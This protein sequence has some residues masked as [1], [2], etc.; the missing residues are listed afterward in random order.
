MP[1]Q[2]SQ[3]CRDLA[4]RE[5]VFARLTA[6][7]GCPDPFEW[8]DGGRTG[9]S[10][11][12]AMLLHITGQ[13]ISAA[14]AF[15]VYDRIS[16]A[17]GGVPEPARILGL[18]PGRLRACGLS[19]AKAGYAVALAQAQEA[20]QIDIEHLDGLADA[21]AIAALTAVPGIGVW[22]AETFLVHNLRRPDVLPA[23]DRGIRRAI[24][25]Q[26]RL[27]ALPPPGQV[28]SRA[29]AWAPW[30]SYAAALLWRSLRPA[31]EPSDPKE[32][33]LLALQAKP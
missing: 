27:G 17:A 1:G 8:H 15:T 23:D 10:R 6:E 9:A 13:R 7:Y 22:S 31:G 30:R 18:G 12:A 33:A 20:G 25:D 24:Q 4:R 16:A 19:A 2:A 26:W 5:P 11:F 32:R 28:R 29:S 3:A 21:D 14:A